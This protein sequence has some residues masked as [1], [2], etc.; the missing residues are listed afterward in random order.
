[1]IAA[2]QFPAVFIASLVGAIVMMMLAGM[3][4]RTR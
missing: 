3:M 2:H 1:V 4:R